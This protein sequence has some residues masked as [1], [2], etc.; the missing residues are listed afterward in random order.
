[1]HLGVR[2]RVRGRGR[3]RIRV[4]IRVRVC[5]LLQVQQQALDPKATID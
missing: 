4:R 1:M 3:G 2:V 5:W